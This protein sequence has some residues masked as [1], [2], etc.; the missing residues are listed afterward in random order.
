MRRVEYP[1]KILYS[2]LPPSLT[3]VVSTIKK[4]HLYLYPYLPMYIY[5]SIYYTI[6][7]YISAYFFSFISDVR[8]LILNGQ[9]DEA[10]QLLTKLYPNVLL[11]SPLC[12]FHLKCQQFIELVKGGAMHKA[13][14]FAQH[15]LA[16]FSPPLGEEEEQHLQ[17]ERVVIV[18]VILL[19]MISIWNKVDR[20]ISH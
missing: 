20:L 2:P 6:L 18:I 13:I 3:G 15:S 4:Y 5:L 7:L 19:P 10:I 14:E 9:I 16:N 11:R 12:V 1:N 17:V 8:K